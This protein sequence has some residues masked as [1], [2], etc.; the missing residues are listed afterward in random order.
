MS[1]SFWAWPV[2]ILVGFLFSYF[3]Y[4]KLIAKSQNWI[5][6]AAFR[7]FGVGLLVWLLFNPS[8]I[9]KSTRI[10][11]P[12]VQIYGDHS[13]SC[14]KESAIVLKRI[15]SLIQSKYGDKVDIQRVVF[16]EDLT[17]V[18]NWDSIDNNRAKQLTRL[19]IVQQNLDKAK[20]EIAGSIIVTDGIANK[21]QSPLLQGKGQQPVIIIG[22]GDTAVYSD[23]A[24]E[25]VNANQEVFE[26]NATQIEIDVKAL[27][28][29]GIPSIIEVYD[30][31]KLI[32][33]TAW[34]PKSNIDRE[35][36][37]LTVRSQKE[38]LKLT[39]TIKSNNFKEGN[40]SNNSLVKIIDVVKNRKEVWLIYGKLNP[41]IKF[42][43]DIISSSNRFKVK[44]ISENN[45]KDILG[46]ICIFHGVQKSQLIQEC[47]NKDIPFWTFLT[48]PSSIVVANRIS[49]AQISGLRRAQWQT[50][51]A[52]PNGNFNDFIIPESQTM[53]NWGGIESPVVKVSALEENVQLYQSWNNVKTDY[54][55]FFKSSKQ[56][57]QLWFLGENIWKWKLQNSKSSLGDKDFKDWVIGN[58]NWLSLSASTREGIKV[59][60]GNGEWVVGQE[61]EIFILERDASGKLRMDTKIKVEILD[62]IGKKTDVQIVKNANSQI[63]SF[64][65]VSGGIHKLRVSSDLNPKAKNIFWS[66]KDQSIE[67]TNRV[68]RFDLLRNWANHNG[69]QFYTKSQMNAILDK[70][71]DFKLDSDRS[72]QDSEQ[73][74]FREL[75]FTLIALI[76]FFSMEWFLRKWLGKI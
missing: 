49:G 1:V 45:V 59:N 76:F 74:T 7:F 69:G 66:V 64:K 15:D 20:S 28:C 4:K 60:I 57:N 70:L 36:I 31:S 11:K 65:P 43:S 25:S 50:I 32:S 67:N 52:E 13:L 2:S 71:A 3:T 17:L 22:I 6:P 37:S 34:T 8:I 30:G 58:V 16:E 14:R 68:A 72:Y 42:L 44:T 56:K 51:T 54:P 47:S 75:I 40:K 23:F 35:K 9:L 41:D 63:I 12:V 62:S 10:E 38:Q 18:S 46:D 19:D 61:N 48:T 33:K 5:I 27:Q 21:G 26:G 53:S 29:L 73:S 24:I 55:L 39:A